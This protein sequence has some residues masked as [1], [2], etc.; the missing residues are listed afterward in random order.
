MA[1]KYNESK[2]K[3]WRW[4]G[5]ITRAREMGG[6]GSETGSAMQRGK[7]IGDYY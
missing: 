1:G 5:N 4:Q 2:G 3:G 7:Q 6:D